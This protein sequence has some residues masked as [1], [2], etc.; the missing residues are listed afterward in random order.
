[1]DLQPLRRPAPPPPPRAYLHSF[2]DGS[3][4]RKISARDLV[5][6]PIWKGNRILN[7]DHKQAILQS[8]KYG[9][10]SL[11]LKP[12]HVVSYPVEAYE[13]AE[14]EIMHYVVDGQHRLS[15]LKE[16]DNLDFD[17]L[18]VE[19]KCES[20]SDVIEYFK[21]L[22]HTRAIEWRED[23][24]VL[25]NRYIVALEKV[26][27]AGK[28]KRIRP[29]ATHRPYLY[30]DTLREELVKRKIGHTGKSPEIFAEFATRKNEGALDILKRKEKREGMEDRALQLEFALALDQKMKWLQEF[31]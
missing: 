24:I 19:K 11:D 5:K 21:I 4:L 16:S 28:E 7:Q 27:N 13:S 6:I 8:L 31:E 18:V 25:A 20:E 22:N 15:I 1:M 10:K 2:S 3:I 17:V 26:F 30:V 29:K 14:E 9:A 23:P 12:F